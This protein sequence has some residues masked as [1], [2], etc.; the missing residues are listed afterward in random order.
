MLA[1]LVGP[2]PL[3]LGCSLVEVGVWVEVG[4]IVGVGVPTGGWIKILSPG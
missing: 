2:V 3:G 1:L 4:S